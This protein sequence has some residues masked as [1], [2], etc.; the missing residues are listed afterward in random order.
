MRLPSLHGCISF[1]IDTVRLFVDKVN[2]KLIKN[3]VHFA[4]QMR[5]FHHF[6]GVQ[7]HEVVL[8]D[9]VS[10]IGEYQGSLPC[11]FNGR[12]VH[13][14]VVAGSVYV[15]GLTPIVNDLG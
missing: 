7:P 9:V 12:A 13:F 14:N 10:Q 6:G 8:S 15:N 4:H 1:Q 2:I 11:L 3:L 5:V